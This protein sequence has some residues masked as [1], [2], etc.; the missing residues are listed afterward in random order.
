VIHVCTRHPSSTSLDTCSVYLNQMIKYNKGINALKDREWS[1]PNQPRL[2]C[3]APY[4]L[5]CTHA[6]RLH[7]DC[8]TT[9][10]EFAKKA[11]ISIRHHSTAVT[12]PLPTAYCTAYR[13]DSTIDCAPTLRPTYYLLRLVDSAAY[14]ISSWLGHGPAQFQRALVR[15]RVH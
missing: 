6:P 10:T 2:G 3:D 4:V 8:V 5:V 1:V 9:I 12:I 13:S 15:R 14:I 7:T 11:W